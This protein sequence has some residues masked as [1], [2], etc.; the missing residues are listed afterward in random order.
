MAYAQGINVDGELLSSM[1]VHKDNADPAF[2]LDCSDLPSLTRQEFAAECDINTLMAQYEKTGVINHFTTG[3]PQYY[4]FDQ[5]PD[6]QNSLHILKEATTAFMSLPAHVRKEFDNDPTQ[7]VEF[8]SD[9]KNL[10]KMREYGLAAPAKVDP[11]PQKVEIV[12]KEPPLDPPT[13]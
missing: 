5:V 11:P 4:D 9:P 8:A 10:D 2:N 7:F 3:E 6:L 13:K 1:Y 12:N